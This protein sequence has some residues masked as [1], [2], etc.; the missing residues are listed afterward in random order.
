MLIPGQIRKFRMSPIKAL[1]YLISPVTTYKK[2]DGIKR[3]MNKSLLTNL[4][5]YNLHLAVQNSANPHECYNFIVEVFAN[6]Q[7]VDTRLFSP[8]T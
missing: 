6:T 2:E 7:A 5:S 8:P 1:L 3:S 4:Q